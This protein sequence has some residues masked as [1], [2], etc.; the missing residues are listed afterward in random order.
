MTAFFDIAGTAFKALA[1]AL[2]TAIAGPF[3]GLAASWIAKKIIG[4]DDATN[5]EIRDLINNVSSPELALKIKEADREFEAQMKQMGVD[6]FK[7]EVQDR[8]SAREF[9]TRGGIGS[10]M[11]AVIGTVVVAGFLYTVWMVIAGDVDIQ[12]ANKAVLIG[13]VVGYVSAKADQVIAFLFGSTHGSKEKTA[14]MSAA[15]QQAMK[16]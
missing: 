5:D 4:K 14:E 8:A 7:L 16:R 2:G 15:L 11:Q 3:G 10:Y 12:D 9:G 1:P 6:V 13:T